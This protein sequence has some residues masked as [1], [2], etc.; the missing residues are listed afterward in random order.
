MARNLTFLFLIMFIGCEMNSKQVIKPEQFI[1]EEVRFD[2]VSK[3]LV[4]KD[5]KEDIDINNMKKIINYWFDNKIKTN[6]FDGLLDV[7]VNNIDIHKLKKL[8]YFKVSIKLVFEFI[9][10]KENPKSRKTYNVEAS[11]YGEIEGSFSINDQENLTLNLMH[12]ALNG[13]SKKLSD[14]N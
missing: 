11:E 5:F 6:G 10:I 8:D 2:S 3:T 7:K 13:V 4:F 1:F 9:E 14:L 12:Q